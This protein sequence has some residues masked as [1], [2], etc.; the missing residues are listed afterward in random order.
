MSRDCCVALPCGALGLS[1]VQ[2]VIVVF[3][4]HSHLLFL[5]LVARKQSP[6]FLSKYDSNQPPE[7]P[8]LARTLKFGM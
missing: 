3:P 8:R 7:L 6:G 5:G 2:F 4:D 1:A